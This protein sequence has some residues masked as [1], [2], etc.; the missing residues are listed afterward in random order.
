MTDEDASTLADY[1]SMVMQSP[2]VDPVEGSSKKSTPDMANLGKQLYEVKYQCQSCH[3]IGSSGG[4]VGPNLTNAGNWINP[5]WAEEW[6]K[7]PQA[8]VPDSIEPLREFTDE[9]RTALTAYLMTLKQRAA[10]PAAGAP[11]RGR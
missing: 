9:E 3:T 10:S 6:L 4:Y 1:L 2:L 7:N 11:G 5:A 8:L